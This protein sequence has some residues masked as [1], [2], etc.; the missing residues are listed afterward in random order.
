MLLCIHNSVDSED[1]QPG[2]SHKWFG[3]VKRLQQV[4][5]NSF[6]PVQFIPGV[7]GSHHRKMP[8]APPNHVGISHG[9]EGRIHKVVY[10]SNQRPEK[11]LE[12]LVDR[13]IKFLPGKLQQSELEKRLHVRDAAQ[14]GF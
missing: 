9:E 1:P 7:P 4:Q 3:A 11:S 10:E 12:I 2:S 13:S 6:Q 5:E 14:V 8:V